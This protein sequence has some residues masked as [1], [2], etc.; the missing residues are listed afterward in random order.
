M[1][2]VFSASKKNFSLKGNDNGLGGE[3]LPVFFCSLYNIE[4]LCSEKPSGACF[5]TSVEFFFS[6]LKGRD[7]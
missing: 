4:K 5:C 2:P 3:K 6:A 7:Q 1:I